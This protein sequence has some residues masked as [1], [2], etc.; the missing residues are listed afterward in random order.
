MYNVP[1][2]QNNLKKSSKREEKKKKNRK[3]LTVRNGLALACW[4]GI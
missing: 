2:W 3:K 4:L 1:G